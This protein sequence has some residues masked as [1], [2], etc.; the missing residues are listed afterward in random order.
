MLHIAV[1]KSSDPD[2]KDA[3]LTSNLQGLE[4]IRRLSTATDRKCDVVGAN[5]VDQLLA[6]I[7]SYRASLAHA[8]IKGTLSV[9]AKT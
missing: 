7:S 5:E 3:S 1:L 8:V 9:S 4:D 6:K 2:C